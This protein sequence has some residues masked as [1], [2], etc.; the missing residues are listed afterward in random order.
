M[1]CAAQNPIQMC[2]LTKI[3]MKFYCCLFQSGADYAYIN[4]AFGPLPAFLYLWVALL[5]I[6]PTGNA[7]TALTFSYYTLQPIFP[8]C[9][10]PD[11]SIRVLA[12]L[13]IGQSWFCTVLDY[14]Q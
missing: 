8:D 6:V 2:M 10:P 1:C 4:V 13:A 7:I 11:T 14:M 12:A 3:I 5:V 9:A